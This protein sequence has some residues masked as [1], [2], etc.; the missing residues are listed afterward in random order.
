LKSLKPGGSLHYAP[1]LPF[2]EFYLDKKQYQIEKHE[3]GQLD[4]KTT[5][6]IRLK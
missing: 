4:F 2:I 3:I 1:D 5:V 6:I